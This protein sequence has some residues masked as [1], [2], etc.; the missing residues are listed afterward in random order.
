[1]RISASNL[2]RDNRRRV[3]VIARHSHGYAEGRA[4]RQASL[5]RLGVDLEAQLSFPTPLG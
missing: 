5:V 3:S 2:T 1:M 4:A